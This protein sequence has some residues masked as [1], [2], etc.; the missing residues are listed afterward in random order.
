MIDFDTNLP[1]ESDEVDSELPF[2]DY[3]IINLREDDLE[4]E[5]NSLDGFRE[6]ELDE[7]SNDNGLT[8]GDY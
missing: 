6:W 1:E 8:Y 7:K 3:T 2:E 4:E 5:F